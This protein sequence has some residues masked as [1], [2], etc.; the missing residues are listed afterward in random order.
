MSFGF[1]VGDFLAAG[2]LIT[3]IVTCLKDSGG[4]ASQYQELMRELD[5]L[6]MALNK[7]EH[8]KETPGTHLLLVLVYS[9]PFLRYINSEKADN[10]MLT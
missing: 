10:I 4:A 5:G 6:Q 9:G 8:L 3:D 2:A 7:I 1:S